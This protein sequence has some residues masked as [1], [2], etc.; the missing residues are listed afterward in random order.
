MSHRK[1]LIALA[2]GDPAGISPELT[3]RLVA[4]DKVRER[5]N[6]LVIGDRRIFDA[7]ARIAGIR[8]DIK[9]ITDNTN[10]N[11]VDGAVFVDLAHL[12]PKHIERGVASQAG[13]RRW[14]TSNPLH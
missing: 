10:S 3:A 8:P 11:A 2:M 12:D 7:G 9:T 4:S 14:R 13:G 5:A 1:P 6:L